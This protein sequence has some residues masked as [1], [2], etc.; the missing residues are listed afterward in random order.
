MEIVEVEWVDCSYSSDT[1]T[2]KEAEAFECINIH[3]VGY[4][5]V[6]DST[7]VTLAKEQYVDDG[8]M[9][10]ITCIPRRNVITETVV[11]ASEA[12]SEDTAVAPTG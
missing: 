2:L 6:S 11:R 1:F 7:R 3:T 5:V 9:R 12:T 8:T 4:L 10:H